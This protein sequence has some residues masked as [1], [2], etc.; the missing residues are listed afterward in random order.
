MIE[1]Q[2][3]LIELLRNNHKEYLTSDDIASYLNISNKT[4]RNDI[5]VINSEFMKDVITSIKSRGYFLNTSCYSLDQID[6]KLTDYLNRDSK[7]IIRIAYELLMHSTSM[8]LNQLTRDYHITKKEVIDYVNRVQMWCEKFDVSIQVLK[9]SGITVNG[10]ENDINNAILHLNQLSKQTDRVEDLI[11][12]ELPKA[13]INSIKQIIEDRLEKHHIFTSQIQIEQLIIHLILIVKR[14]PIIEKSWYIDNESMVIANQIVDDINQKLG[15]RIS[16][17]TAQLFSFFISYHF[18]KFDLGFERI[19]IE[20]YIQK[21]IIKMERKLK[22]KFSSDVVLKENLL[23]H[24]S[25]TYLR[26][27]KEVYLNNPLTSEIKIL[28][29]YVFNVLY[30]IINELANDSDIHLSE[31]EIAFLTIHFQA[32]IDRNEVTEINVVICCYYGLG[33]AQLLETKIS[34]INNSINVIDILKLEDID[35]YKFHNIDVIITTHDINLA[36][37]ENI[38]V[39]K[40]SPLFSEEDKLKLN[41]VVKD[42]MNPLNKQNDLNEI[43]FTTVVDE[44]KQTIP[45]VFE[46]AN[47]ILLKS[48]S[49]SDK[50]IETALNREKMSSTYIGNSMTMPHGNPDEVLK[51]QVII[52]KSTEG[53]YWKEHHVKLVFFLAIKKQDVHLMKQMM[54]KLAIFTEEDIQLLANLEKKDFQNTIMNLLQK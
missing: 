45:N 34:N 25:R 37:K 9:K 39:I 22:V 19:F 30:D 21:M 35:S 10:R 36:I 26:I 5:K 23:S 3:K 52:F 43:S 49:I 24:F 11:L 16:K 13:H 20:S 31:D 44:F 40:V 33:I 1:R 7:M 28:Y 47:Q 6:D 50:Y 29:P 54:Q 18:N 48:K 32:S 46:V 38:E 53:F 2:V 17:Q 12:N 8:S 27:I 41:Q 14:H 4:A 42:K 15:Y 51:S